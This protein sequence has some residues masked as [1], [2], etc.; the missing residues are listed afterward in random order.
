MFLTRA[1]LA[2]VRDVLPG[3]GPAHVEYILGY[4]RHRAD[5]GEFPL[6]HVRNSAD[7]ARRRP[8][9]ERA[10]AGIRRAGLRPQSAQTWTQSDGSVVDF[11]GRDRQGRLVELASSLQSPQRYWV[12]LSYVQDPLTGDVYRLPRGAF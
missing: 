12:R 1:L 5:P 3:T 9:A 2:S 6:G 7:P 11:V 10:A 8:G 4:Q